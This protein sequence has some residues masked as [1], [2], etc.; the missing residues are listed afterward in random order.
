MNKSN[1]S[2]GTRTVRALIALGSGVLMSLAFPPYDLGNW[3]W[4]G[5]IPLLCVLWLG[6]RGFWRGFA[7]SWLYGIGWYSSC[8]WWVNE[9]GHTFRIPLVIFLPVAFLPMMALFSCLPGLWGGIANT[10]L[11]PRLETAPVTPMDMPLH[12]RRECWQAWSRRDLGS[13]LRCATGCAA[14]W[15][16]VEWARGTGAYSCGW[17]SMGMALYGGLSMV[18]WAEFVGTM[19]L[20]FIPVFTSVILWGAARRSWKQ[21]RGLGKGCIPWDF[22]GTVIVLFGLFLG[23]LYLSKS[24]S[25]N[26]M[27]RR[28]S[29]LQLPVMGLQLNLDQTERMESGSL[30]PEYYGMLLRQTAQGFSQIQRDTVSRAMQNTEVGIIQQLPVWVVW[31]ESGMGT[32]LY[33]NQQSG[34]L[35]QDAYTANYLL[36]AHG[37]PAVRKLVREMGGQDFVIF[38]GADEVLW[39][40][41][42]AGLYNSMAVIPGDFSSISTHPK[43]HLMPFGEYVPLARE[44][45]WIG[46]AYAAIT[47]M[48]AGDGILPGSGNETLSVPVPG[49]E[50]KI[51]VIPA[52]CYED[53]VGALLTKYVRK[54]PQVIV[55]VSNDAWFRDSV[56]GQQQARSAAFRCIELRRPMIR[57]ANKGLTCA[58]AP[59]GAVL[60]SLTKADGSPHLAGFSYAVLPVDR[61]AGF[62]LYALLGDWA[63]AVCALLALVLSLAG[64]KRKA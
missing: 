7:Y 8:F 19:A 13:T 49:T 45:K 41:G 5:L 52:I 2:A 58:I 53:T 30:H 12:K 18:Q 25:P 11:R 10:L 57:A 15:V 54:G 43:Q 48:S 56:C 21:F 39:D 61:H 27:M 14:L 64:L 60:D 23:G 55:N 37:L 28:D 31:P 62:T 47:G 24:Y 20:S 3:V 9:V 36:H 34:E 16:C 4:V 1:G 17:N 40:K 6:R 35:L 22:Y 51:E 29:T 46:D 44:I 38:T 42:P 33:R 32:P 63:V 26:V 50:E 59:N